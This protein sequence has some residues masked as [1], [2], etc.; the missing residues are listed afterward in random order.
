MAGLSRFDWPELTVG[1][2]FETIVALQPE[3]T[4]ICSGG[5]TLTFA[6]LNSAA[7]AMAARVVAKLGEGEIPVLLDGVT[8]VRLLVAVLGLL[9]AGKP[10]AVVNSGMGQEARQSI[11]EDLEPGLILGAEDI[12]VEQ[13]GAPDPPVS[14]DGERAASIVY[15]SG[16][17]AKP[18]GVVRT[19]RNLLHRAWTYRDASD[20]GPGDVQALMAPL[21]HVGAESDLFGAWMNGAQISHYPASLGVAG[22]TAWLTTQLVTLWHPPVGLLRRW[23]GLLEAPV[24]LP[25]LRMIAL[26]GEAVYGSDVRL[27]RKLCG[28]QMRILHRYSSSEA[29][30][31]TAYEVGSNAVPDDQ[32]LPAGFACPD[33]EVQVSEHGEVIVRSEF[34]SRGYWKVSAF[35]GVYATGDLGRFDANGCLHL[36]GRQDRR[37]KVRGFLV[38]LTEVEGVL[39]SIE[40]V[41]ELAVI[42]RGEMLLAY[43]VRP[44]AD[45]Q[46]QARE[47][48]S[49]WMLPNAFVALEQLPLTATGKVDLLALP[50]PEAKS[51]APRPGLEAEL[52]ELWR[53]VL[54]REQAGATD[55]FFEMGGD[56]LRAAELVVR[57][58]RLVGREVPASALYWA[59]TPRAMREAIE[60]NQLA[61]GRIVP[62]AGGVGEP[63]LLLPPPPNGTTFYRDLPAQI[64]AP[65]YGVDAQWQRHQVHEEARQIA[66]ELK[67]RWPGQ[68]IRLAGFSFG[69]NLAFEVAKLMEGQ[70]QSVV[71]IDSHAPGFLTGREMNHGVVGNRLAV[72]S[73]M[74]ECWGFEIRTWA[75]LRGDARKTFARETLAALRAKLNLRFILRRLFTEAPATI[76]P[77]GARHHETGVYAGHV[78]VIRFATP[79]PGTSPDPYLGWKRWATGKLTAETLPGVHLPLIFL[80]PWAGP[81]AAALRSGCGSGE[82]D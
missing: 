19:H 51:E 52:V 29:G 27:I 57:I 64:G 12:V 30:N 46:R 11:V 80:M 56:S 34:V 36:K 5:E 50:V 73:Y 3:A 31:I 28:E 35:G 26:G 74:L 66:A 9:K 49:P 17:T 47:K 10:F 60:N 33:R 14:F 69:G 2:R 53:K 62:L 15:T 59:P 39:R 65:V 77:P 8:D 76:G 18:K 7:N 40:G 55:H 67:A 78:H 75:R 42:A 1:Q 23:L 79:Y 48:L 82:N 81:I 68:T 54:G 37:V 6:Q 21:S 63:W 25:A 41:G 20:V 13:S 16:S 45:L 71:L 44:P 43:V 70:I 61:V 22:L 4:A 32:V 72:W 58:S 38:D 24:Q